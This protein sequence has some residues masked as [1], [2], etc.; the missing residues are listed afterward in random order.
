LIQKDRAEKI[1]RRS[2]TQLLVILTVGIG[3]VIYWV[4]VR[5]QTASG[6]TFSELGTALVAIFAAGG[7]FYVVACGI[8]NMI[9][10]ICGEK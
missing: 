8:K 10:R 1:W 3:I 5:T 6:P 4:I 2:V 9:V 7:A